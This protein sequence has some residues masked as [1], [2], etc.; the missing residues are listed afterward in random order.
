MTNH[1]NRSRRASNPA[2]EAIR[3][4]RQASG[5]SAREAAALVYRGQV[6]WYRWEAGEQPMDPALWELWQIKSAQ[7]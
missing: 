1:P 2:P 4:A 6:A 7:V 5:L 3:A